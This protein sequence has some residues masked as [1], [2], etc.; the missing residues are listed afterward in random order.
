MTHIP[1]SSGLVEPVAEAGRLARDAGV[2]YL[3]DATQSVGHLPVDVREIGC[4]LLVTTG[5][6]YLRGP[7]GTALLYVRSEL[8]E[9]LEPLAPDVR[10]AT[11]TADRAWSLDATARRFE[12]W[13]A[14]HACASGSAS[15]SPRPRRSASRRSPSTSSRGAR[16]CARVSPRSRA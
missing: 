2:T 4:D 15:R 13:E 11:W 6:K 1:T 10:G 9:R 7:R 12:T 3:L 14:S 8:L 16:G 5:R